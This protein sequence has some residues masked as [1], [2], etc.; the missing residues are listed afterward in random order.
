MNIKIKIGTDGEKNW[1]NNIVLNEISPSQEESAQET[2][3]EQL[4][5]H[6]KQITIK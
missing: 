4:L 1:E 5:K 6:K 3:K 2:L